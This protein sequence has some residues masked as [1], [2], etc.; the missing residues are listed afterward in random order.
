[1]L[2]VKLG[3]V[4]REKGGW[5]KTAGREGVVSQPALPPPWSLGTETQATHLVHVEGV[6]THLGRR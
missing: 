1:M 6:E 2:L 4:S 5:L 3:R